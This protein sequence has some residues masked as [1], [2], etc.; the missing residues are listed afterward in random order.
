[1]IA[2]SGVAEILC[3]IGMMLPGPRRA[4]RW[5]T[6]ALLIAVFPANVYMATNGIQPGKL[7]IPS[8][9][10]WLRLPLQPLLIWWMLAVTSG[11]DKKGCG[12]ETAA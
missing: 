9:L 5:G 7:Q 3:G 6:V 8:I 2:I 12:M 4:A 10:L 1:M 11:S